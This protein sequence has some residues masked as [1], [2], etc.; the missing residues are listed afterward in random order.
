MSRRRCTFTRPAPSPLVTFGW[1]FFTGALA[2]CIAACAVL[3][4][5]W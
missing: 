4:A 5:L 3:V 2:G 1:A